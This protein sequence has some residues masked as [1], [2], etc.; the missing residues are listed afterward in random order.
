M[1]F[2]NLL[3]RIDELEISPGRIP[4]TDKNGNRVWLM[5]DGMFDFTLSIMRLRREDKNA[6]IPSNL[7]EVVDLWSRA[8]IE[9]IDDC[10]GI[11]RATHLFAKRILEE[12]G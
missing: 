1:K 5:E 9:T 3:K 11:V 12:G 4:T 6:P 8:E 7:R 2:D 10:P